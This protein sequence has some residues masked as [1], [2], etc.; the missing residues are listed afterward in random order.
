M[1][2]RTTA[3][4]LIPGLPLA[5]NSVDLRRFCNLRQS[6]SLVGP[7]HDA[8]QQQRGLPEPSI[9]AGRATMISAPHFGIDALPPA[10]RP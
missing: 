10:T 6:R 8:P 1:P 3:V 9:L 5:E 2:L 4:S 7:F